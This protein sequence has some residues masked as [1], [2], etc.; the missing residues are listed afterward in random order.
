MINSKKTIYTHA[1]KYVDTKKLMSV[2]EVEYD[3]NLLLYFQFNDSWN[4]VKDIS[5]Y[6]PSI[7]FLAAPNVEAFHGTHL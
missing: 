2:E 5:I 4:S 7:L 1:R 3:K 6:A